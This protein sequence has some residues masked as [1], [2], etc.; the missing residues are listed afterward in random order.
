VP[1]ID[2]PEGLLADVQPGHEREGD[3]AP[4]RVAREQPEDDPHVAVRQALALM[5]HP[6]IATVLDAGT[7]DDARP[8]FVR[9]LRA[10]T[11]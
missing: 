4:R 5:D 8:Y 10:A 6:H 11:C 9:S 1:R 2:A 3:G 7:T